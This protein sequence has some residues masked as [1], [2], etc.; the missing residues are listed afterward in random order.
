[1]EDVD[2]LAF[3]QFFPVWQRRPN[4]V[5]ELWKSRSDIYDPFPLLGLD[6]RRHALPEVC[7]CVD[8]VGAIESAVQT[9]GIVEISLDKLDTL[10][11]EFFALC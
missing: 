8:D 2:E 3:G 4:K 7:H 6:S 10:F 5:L 11:G 1:M 9:F